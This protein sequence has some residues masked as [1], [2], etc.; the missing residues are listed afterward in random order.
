MTI[1]EL[2][3]IIGGQ[4]TTMFDYSINKNKDFKVIILKVENMNNENVREILRNGF[5]AEI[6]DCYF[7]EENKTIIQVYVRQA[8]VEHLEFI[9]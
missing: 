1:S 3:S 7:A 2:R 6:R 5:M 8:N 4:L 9:D